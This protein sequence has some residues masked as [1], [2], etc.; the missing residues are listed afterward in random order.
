M[1]SETYPV[2]ETERLLLRPLQESDLDDM[3]SLYSNPSVAAMMEYHDAMI[4]F[5]KY[6]KEFPQMVIG[7]AY[8]TIRDKETDRFIGFILLHQYIKQNKISYSQISTAIRPEHWGK[9]YCTEAAKKLLHFAF[10]SI[11]TPWICANQFQDNPAA[12]SVLKRCGLIFYKTYK[13]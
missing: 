2:L 7:G 11:K 5:P 12:G 8:L 4:G 9:G 1:A 6:Q 13:M 3:Y 10:V